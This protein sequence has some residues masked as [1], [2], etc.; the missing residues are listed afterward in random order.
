MVFTRSVTTPRH[1]RRSEL[2]VIGS[3]YALALELYLELYKYGSILLCP[4][5]F[6]LPP[7]SPRCHSAGMDGGGARTVC[8]AQGVRAAQASSF[9]PWL[10]RTNEQSGLR[11]GASPGLLSVLCQTA[12][13]ATAPT[14]SRFGWEGSRSSPPAG[15][16]RSVGSNTC[17]PSQTGALRAG[18]AGAPIALTRSRCW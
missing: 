7:L 15:C 10:A 1:F 2:L 11:D 17:G 16:R 3:L 13:T 18:K 14:C 8:G 6:V 5:V 4:S 9:L 12:T